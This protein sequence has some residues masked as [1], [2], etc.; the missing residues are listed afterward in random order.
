MAPVTRRAARKAFTPSISTPPVLEIPEVLEMILLQIDMRT[1]LI[2][3]QRVCRDW[4]DLIT[5][6]L[7][8]QKPLFFTPIKESEWGMGEKLPN[9][10]LAEM[11]PAIFPAE[12]EPRKRDFLF[13]D[14]VMTKD[15]ASLDRFVQKDA[16]WR[17]MLVQQ[18]PILELG[19]FHID[20]ARGG[21]SALCVIIP[22]NLMKQKN[23]DEGLRMGRLFGIL[24]FDSPIRVGKFKSAR[25][26]WLLDEPIDFHSRQE[27][28]KDAFHQMLGQV[29]LV[30]HTK[31]IIQCAMGFGRGF[32]G[33][34]T[35][36]MK[37]IAAYREHGLDVD[38]QAEEMKARR[39]SAEE[40]ELSDI[41][42]D[43]ADSEDLD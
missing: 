17:R 9:L 2:S 6:S 24:L 23:R 37:I 34:K 26:Y 10:L 36:K 32:S 25:L 20:S 21:D 14:C 38:S 4:R 18:P 12:G 41:D 7:S 1:L 11:F 5:K 22:A 29:G 30:L 15:P 19:L 42:S 3:C 35:T 31:Q 16:S 40:I 27:S 28:N 33:V 43:E 8:I 39:R 13:S